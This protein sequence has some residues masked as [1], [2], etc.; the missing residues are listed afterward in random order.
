MTTTTR[1]FSWP[2]F[3]HWQAA[4]A[5]A[6]RFP[7]GW[8]GLECAPLAHTPEAEAYRLR[9]FTL[10]HEWLDMLAQRPVVLAHYARQGISIRVE[11]QDQRSSCP[12]C[13][14][15]HGRE[16]GSHLDAIPPFHPGCRCVLVALHP[17]APRRRARP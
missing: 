9:K 16:V 11:R 5:A 2:D 15:F 13:D 12:A 14:P 4:F 17:G 10:F 7:P 1:D 8:E 6:G 3:D